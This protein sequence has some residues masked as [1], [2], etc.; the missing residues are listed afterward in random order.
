MFTI[1]QHL[2]ALG[3]EGVLQESGILLGGLSECEELVRLLTGDYGIF[4]LWVTS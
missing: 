4:S 1:C 2:F 3:V